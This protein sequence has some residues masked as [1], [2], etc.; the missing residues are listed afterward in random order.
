M[1]VVMRFEETLGDHVGDGQAPSFG[2]LLGQAGDVQALLADD[3][4]LVGLQLAADQ[5]QERAL[6]LAV[7]AQQADPLPALDLPIDLIQDPRTPERECNTPQAEQCHERVS[8]SC[9]RR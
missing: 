1:V 5:P 9:V 2:D 7:P 4:A 8:S 3:L 6:P